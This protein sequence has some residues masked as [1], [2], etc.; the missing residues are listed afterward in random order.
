MVSATS[1]I[2]SQEKVDFNKLIQESFEAD[3]SKEK[4]NQQIKRNILKWSIKKSEQDTLSQK[5][6]E[7]G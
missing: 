1:K 2:T 5:K 6:S 3:M 4:V 7:Y